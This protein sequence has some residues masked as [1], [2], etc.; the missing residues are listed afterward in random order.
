MF[1]TAKSEIID[2]INNSLNDFL[3][4]DLDN[5]HNELFNSGYYVVGYYQASEKIKQWG[6]D[7]FDVIEYVQNYERDNF[8]ETN[9]DINSESMLNMFVYILGEEILYSLN[10]DFDGDLDS[11]KLGEIKEA[12]L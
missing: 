9:T 7:G 11:E 12:L 2:Y 1:T 6:L 4:T 5:L 3:N 10:I 8:G